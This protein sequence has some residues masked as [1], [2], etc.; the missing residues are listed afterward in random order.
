MQESGAE[1]IHQRLMKAGIKAVFLVPGAQVDPLSM[2]LA[3]SPQLTTV[4]AN[5]ELAAG[6]M[7]DGYARASHKVGVCVGIGACGAANMLPAAATAAADDS[8]VLFLTG[9]IASSM[10]G[11]GAFQD[12]GPGGSDDSA[13]FR[14]FVRYSALPES[15]EA[16]RYELDRIFNLISQPLRAP[17][18]LSIPYD[19]QNQTSD[20]ESLAGNWHVLPKGLDPDAEA[21]LKKIADA[22]AISERPLLLVGP[23]FMSPDAHCVLRQ[24]AETYCVPVATTLSA[25][26]ILPEIHA[27]SL[28]NFGFGGSRRAQEAI[29]RGNAD[30]VLLL[31]ADFNERD[32]LSWDS[33]I[34]SDG[35]QI[36]RVDSKCVDSLGI[37]VDSQVTSDSVAAVRHWLTC[38][39]SRLGPLLKSAPERSSWTDSLLKTPHIY[40]AEVDSSCPDGTL[41]LDLV[42]QTLRENVPDDTILVVD[43]G[44]HRIFAGHYWKT[45]Q[46]GTF[47]SACATVPMGWAVCASIGI[48]IARSDQPVVVLTGD[49]CMRAQGLELATMVRYRLPIV[50]IVCNNGAYGSVFRRVQ[51]SPC[52]EDLTVLPPV[53]WVRFATALGARAHRID[54]KTKLRDSLISI[55]DE[56][57]N[58]SKAERGPFLLDVA[59]PLHQKIPHPELLCSSLANSASLSG[60]L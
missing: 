52:G 6:F 26:G 12:A 29:L 35:R 45:K 32:S 8:A 42:V 7:A 10:N 38:S 21:G 23:R 3:K 37:E 4:I 47:F 53:D 28:G 54:N 34:K 22:L 40:G 49:G 5:H 24:F 36:M 48:Q 16:L 41:P 15:T 14:Q 20:G 58:T 1:I 46:P 50:T 51:H 11:Y 57:C 33:R 55:F 39:D 2:E 18:H 27:L 31:G 44:L 43:A 17:A 30:T 9:N 19:V 13:I 60:R 56:S 59:T 25:K